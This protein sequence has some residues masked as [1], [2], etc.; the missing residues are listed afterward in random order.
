VSL[1]VV[2]P[3]PLQAYRG[4]DYSVAIQVNKPD[5]TPVN[6]TVYGTTWKAQAR[7][8]RVATVAYD[9]TVDATAAATGRLVLA[10]TSEVTATLPALIGFDIQGT[11][12]D[13]ITTI[14]SGKIQVSGEWT[15]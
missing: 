5:T 8:S 1:P 15:R 4:D 7:T 11:V 10:L 2:M 13:V 12:G 3:T 6:L 14:L 9:F